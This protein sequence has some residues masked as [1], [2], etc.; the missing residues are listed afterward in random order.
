VAVAGQLHD[1]D[2]ALG[3]DMRG[4]RDGAE[5]AGQEVVQQGHILPA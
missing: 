5:A 2:V 3:I 4:G 1:L